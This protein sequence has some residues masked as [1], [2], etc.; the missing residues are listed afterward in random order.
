[1]LE[2]PE[3]IAG[4][5]RALRVFYDGECPFCSQY[6]TMLRLQK[7][8]MVELIDLRTAN[9]TKRELE[10]AGYE[11]DQGMVVADGGRLYGG[12]DA[13]A[14]L[15]ALSTRSGLLNRLNRAIFSHA[16]AARLLYPLLRS[17]RWLA[18]FLLNRR[19][20]DD[21]E[22]TSY[23]RRE[24][25]TTFFSL[26]SI[27]HFFNY[28]FEYNRFPRSWDLLLVLVAAVAALFRPS[29][30]RA[31]FL[32]VLVST[33]STIVQAPVS[34]NHT[35]VR[36]A[37]LL[38]YWLSFAVAMARN[39]H[40]SR[41]FERFAPAGCGT[42]LVMY[43]FGIF[44]KLNSD[45]LNPITSCAMALWRQ[46]PTPL[47]KLDGPVIEYG[48]IYGT[49]I[50]EGA[51]A[52]ALLTRRLR[53]VGIAAGIAFHLLLSLSSY[54]MYI[55]FTMLALALHTLF[56][57][58]SAARSITTSP[59]LRLVR[60]KLKEPVYKAVVL[61]FISWLAVYAIVGNY[62]AASLSVFPLVLPFCWAVLRYG[63]Q[64]GPYA[65]KPSM[66]VVGSIVAT[67]FFVNCSLPYMGLKTA[68]A[69]N[70]FANLRLEA[71]VS[72]HL[73][74]SSMH[75]PFGYLDQVALMKDHGGEPALAWTVRPDQGIVFYDLLAQLQQNPELR[76]SF[77]INGVSYS[78]VSSADMVDHMHMLHPAWFRK[79]FHFQPVS[80][81]TPEACGV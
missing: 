3:Q 17:G 77:D 70:M 51:I 11:L 60:A 59:F 33:V 32:L 21:Q 5:S 42:L 27:F 44:H 66:L 2:A 52:G 55:S 58:E 14:Y 69:V 79:F 10:L 29:S 4:Q 31:L 62:T 74:F 46:M 8:A 7:T 68:Q 57:N 49:F 73:V 80:L 39:D 19:M 24:V 50:I 16:Q 37:A 48:T 22:D 35:M 20:I 6:V 25:F 54:A 23:A 41:V 72:N 34:S 71:G 67:L 65:S 13:V 43:F 53:H 26:F 78:D 1:M 30:T 63:S 47:A 81:Q 56:L 9:Q 45:F 76:V 38:G 28:A 64:V 15:A 75:R 12:A 40:V 18:L 61:S 36:S